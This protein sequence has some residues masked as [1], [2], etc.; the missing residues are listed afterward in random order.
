[1]VLQEI[2]KDTPYQFP[3]YGNREIIKKATPEIISQFI[4]RFFS[5]QNCSLAII[6]NF[7]IPTAEALVKT[8]F[9]PISPVKQPAEPSFTQL[10]LKRS[11]HIEHAIDIKQ[12]HLFLA[13]PAPKAGDADQLHMQI[14]G[15]LL[16]QGIYPLL[17]SHLRFSKKLADQ[18]DIRYISLAHGGA[19]IIMLE[20]PKKNLKRA[21]METLKFLNNLTNYNFSRDDYL[22]EF[23]SRAPDFLQTTKHFL[24]FDMEQMNESGRNLALNIARHLTAS[25]NRKKKPSISLYDRIKNTTS[26]DLRKASQN[27]L[28]G[29]KYVALTIQPL[30]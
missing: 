2:F 28:A 22:V 25:K 7:N 19:F 23:Q 5:P 10:G 9:S 1:L 29:K 12:A 18:V 11:I 21:E 4:Q 8:M 26:A 3:V 24:A 27:W 15:R 6:G 14:L 13:F 20:L 30:K 17:T 16:T